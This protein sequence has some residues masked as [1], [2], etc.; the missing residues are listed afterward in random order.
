MMITRGLERHIMCARIYGF[1]PSAMA[2]VM[3]ATNARSGG[4]RPG[5]P[6]NS[7]IGDRGYLETLLELAVEEFGVVWIHAH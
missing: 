7:V 3:K 6:R 2:R 5:Q 1:S 4:L